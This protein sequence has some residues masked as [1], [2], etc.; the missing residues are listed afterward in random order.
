MSNGTE[1]LLYG[2]GENGGTPRRR[3]RFSALHRLR[4]RSPGLRVEAYHGYG[5]AD[6][7]FLKGRVLRDP[8]PRHIDANAGAFRN[9]KNM[10]RRALT[11]QVAQ[12][13]V[14]AQ[15]DGA[16]LEAQADDE[17][18]FGVALPLGGATPDPGWREVELELL[19]PEPRP[20]DSARTTA[21]VLVPPGGA[22]FGVV[23]DIDDTV[24]RTEATNLL[25]MLRIVL[26]TNAHSRM[27]FPRVDAL[28]QALVRGGDGE[29]QNPIFY[30]SSSPWNLFDLLAE[31]MR[32]HGLPEG[33]LFLR[34]WN[35]SP[36]QMRGGHR[37]HKIVRL[38]HL[39]DV[40]P[41]LP[42]VL[43]GD[44]GQEDPEI[45]RDAVREYP[46]RVKAIYIRDVTA[47]NRAMAVHAIRDEVETLGVPLLLVDDKTDAAVH[48]AEHGLITRDA[49]RRMQAT[50][51]EPEP[52]PDLLEKL[53]NPDALSCSRS[54]RQ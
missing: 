51:A 9:A 50:D 31:F 54:A 37:D 1:T 6:T 41:D 16:A 33:P 8:G 40:Y 39:F 36:R 29:Q 7:L 43:I 15:F 26:L 30:L 25:R 23:S 38:R 3:G 22:Q 34:D 35:F 4:L 21:R 28:Y 18:Y 27:P 11:D 46:G 48:A 14:R 52:E 19:D 53:V 20:P 45:Y 32:V 10:L 2:S 13:R 47:G 12:A 42:W 49:L 17:G 44:S 5:T 24:V